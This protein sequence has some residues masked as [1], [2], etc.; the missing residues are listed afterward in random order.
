MTG[1]WINPPEHVGPLVTMPVL[2]DWLS[3]DPLLIWGTAHRL[4]AGVYLISFLSWTPQVLF[5]AGSKGIQPARVTVQA[6]KKSYPN[7]YW[8]HRPSWLWLCQE[9][10]FL[11]AVPIVGALTSVCILL[12]AVHST[13]GM[14]FAHSLYLTIATAVSA[15]V[16]PWDDMLLVSGRV[17]MCLPSLAVIA[18]IAVTCMCRRPVFCR[19]FCLVCR[20]SVSS[21][22]RQSCHCPS[23]RSVCAGSLSA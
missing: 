1:L 8:I 18:V 13:I 19:C 6:W 3:F 11:S 2:A 9:D 14:L 17:P 20:T 4:I 23:S 22:R 15:T 5:F 10:W 16:F 7:T 21:G 12:G